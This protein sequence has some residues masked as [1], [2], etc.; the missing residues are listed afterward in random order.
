MQRGAY[1]EEINQNVRIHECSHDP[2]MS[3]INSSADIVG[4]TP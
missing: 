2:L 3:F 1:V 4:T